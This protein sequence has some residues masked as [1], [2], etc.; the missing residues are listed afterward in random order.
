MIVQ[1]NWQTE[2]TNDNPKT[3]VINDQIYFIKK[4]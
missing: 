2:D 3:S 1:E 4:Y